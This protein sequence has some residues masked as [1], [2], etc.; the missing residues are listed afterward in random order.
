MTPTSALLAFREDVVVEEDTAAEG[1]AGARRTLLVS[2]GPSRFTLTGARPEVAR[3][4]SRM[5]HEPADVAAAVR[6]DPAC[7]RQMTAVLGRLGALLVHHVRAGEE[8]AVRIES[9]A[10]APLAAAPLGTRTSVRMSRFALCRTVDGSPVVESPLSGFRAV[11]PG[12]GARRLVADLFAGGTPAGMADSTGIEV[13]DVLG[14]VAHL[15]GAALVDVDDGAGFP[16]DR[17]PVL[18]QWEFHDLL[19]HA[20][21]R[22]GSHEGGYGAVF[23]HRGTVEPRPVVRTPPQG[24]AIALHR[25]PLHTV[26]AKDVPL[27]VAVEG[28]RSV[29]DRGPSP[30]SL[31]ELGEFLYRTARVRTVTEALPEQGM[32]YPASSR[33]YPS[34]GAAYD[35]ELYL[36][37]NRVAG[38]APGM[39]HYD[40]A[41]HALVLVGDGP[42]HR[43]S[44]LDWARRA[45]GA[46]QAADVH[47]TVTSRFQRLSWKYRGMAYAAALKHVGVLYQTMYL[48]ATAMGL[49]PCALGGGDS[50]LTAAALG[51]DYLQE[52]AVGEFLLSSLPAPG[53]L[54]PAVHDGWEP[55]NDHAWYREARMRLESGR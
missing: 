18:A 44:V 14:L 2:L 45:T 10:G 30:L 55:V 12:A 54:P 21:S 16:A 46:A 29:R 50:D 19:F 40:P 23:A 33:P 1:T 27:T 32:P 42:E 36:T 49:A 48:V 3:L 31:A 37:V 26:L 13:C 11:L 34:A 9:S 20:R 41:G 35:L 17:D 39:Y 53:A 7:A 24:P 25:P 22:A 4:L 38:L 15:A 43:Q 5:T 47:I 6:D 8:P 52:S 51:L 28:R